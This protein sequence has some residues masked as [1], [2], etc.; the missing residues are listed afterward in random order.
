[1]EWS[2]LSYRVFLQ[3]F[4]DWNCDR[5]CVWLETNAGNK[6]YIHWVLQTDIF[7]WQRNRLSN[8]KFVDFLG[9]HF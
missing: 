1:M 3:E 2:R 6:K 4:L 7:L 5:K 8:Q 9:A